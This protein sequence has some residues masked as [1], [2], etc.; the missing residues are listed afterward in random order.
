MLKK[1]RIKRKGEK[2]M[3]SQRQ[4][5]KMNHWIKRGVAMALAL[6]I[7]LSFQISDT[8]AAGN[9]ASKAGVYT[10]PVVSLVSKAPMPAINEAF[11]HAFGDTVEVTIDEAGNQV[12]KVQLQHMIISMMG[13]QYHANI[14]SVEGATTLSTKTESYSNMKGELIEHEVADTVSVPLTAG[15]DGKYVLSVVVDYMKNMGTGVTLDLDW[16]QAKEV[17]QEEPVKPEEP[18]K[19]TVKAPTAV[20]VTATYNTVSLS[21]KKVSNATGYEVYRYNK[22]TKKYSK[23]ATVSKTTYKNE[24]LAT[25]TKYTYK[26]RAYKKTEDG[27][28]VTSAFSK[29]VSATPSLGKVTGVTVK[30]SAKGQA[31]ITWKGVSGATGYTVYRATSKTGTYRVVKT[32]S[33]A[34][35]YVNKNLTKK[36][37]YYYKVRA[38][39]MVSGKKVYGNTSLAKAVTIKK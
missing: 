28:N 30:N 20:K 39:R 29:S 18:V 1:R 11:S 15:E 21:W 13:S 38:Y 8:K 24:K 23:I 5:I 12:A 22:T 3:M 17:Q 14:E 36:K 7:M 16:D 35:S 6:V 9:V 27:S 32:G 34:K 26:V 31:K 33:V 10:V 4:K 2:T 37:T 25:G 19:V